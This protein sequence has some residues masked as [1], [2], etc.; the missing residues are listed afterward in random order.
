MTPDAEDNDALFVSMDL[1]L[2]QLFICL[3]RAVVKCLKTMQ[4]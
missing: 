4:R 3:C 1:L 2:V